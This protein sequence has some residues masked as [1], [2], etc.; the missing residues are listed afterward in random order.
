MFLLPV[1]TWK[2]PWPC[3]S[4]HWA[5]RPASE[6]WPRGFD[7]RS[8]DPRAEHWPNRW[9]PS[10]RHLATPKFGETDWHERLFGD[11]FVVVAVVDVDVVVDDNWSWSG[12]CDFSPLRFRFF[13]LQ[14][15]YHKSFLSPRRLGTQWN[16][17]EKHIKFCLKQF[18]RREILLLWE[19]GK[20]G[21]EKEKEKE[22]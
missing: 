6:R 4:R 7:S 14:L 19:K 16:P 12:C 8:D 13:L 2:Q 21:K 18:P 9:A 11:V 5:Q 10:S 17:G 20:K 1:P 15:N 3:C 22:R